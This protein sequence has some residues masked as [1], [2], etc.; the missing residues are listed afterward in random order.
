MAS[1][2]FKPQDTILGMFRRGQSLVLRCGR[3]DCRRRVEVDLADAV[4][5]GVGHY[6]PGELVERLRCQHYRGCRLEEVVASYAEGVPLVAYINSG[7]LIL[8][9]CIGCRLE[10][11]LPAE[12]VIDRLQSE[13]RGNSATGILLLARTI[14]GPCKRCRGTTFET[15][16]S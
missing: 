3:S 14:R 5:G 6:R 11:A 2:R 15:S 10:V 13:K 8:I 7:R 1:K 16:A 9:R 4:H 12:K